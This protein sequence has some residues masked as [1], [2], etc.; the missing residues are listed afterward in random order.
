MRMIQCSKKNTQMFIKSVNLEGDYLMYDLCITITIIPNSWLKLFFNAKWDKFRNILF[1]FAITFSG[2]Q[3]KT[4][5]KI[6]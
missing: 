1:S 5:I 3:L 2:L 6:T 4:K